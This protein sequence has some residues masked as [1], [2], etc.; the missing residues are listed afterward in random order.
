MEDYKYEFDNFVFENDSD[1]KYANVLFVGYV[2]LK[3][4][5]RQDINQ[6]QVDNKLL[7]EIFKDSLEDGETIQENDNI[8]ILKLNNIDSDIISY[9]KMLLKY[10]LILVEDF[11]I[12]N[13][14][15]IKWKRI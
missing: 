2:F 8:F 5:V 7:V 15:T 4:F 12:L 10:C 14:N 9:V 6:F 1:Y 3:Q 13:D 11:E